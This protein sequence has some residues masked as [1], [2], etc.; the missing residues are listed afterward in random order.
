MG[1]RSEQTGSES[2]HFSTVLTVNSPR[3]MCH[4]GLSIHQVS[5]DQLRSN[6]DH[7]KI[8]DKQVGNCFTY[9]AEG[10]LSP[11]NTAAVYVT[12]TVCVTV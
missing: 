11:S 1:K 3:I 2:Q 8:L 7:H 12:G 4:S 5:S 6:M 10:S 9:K